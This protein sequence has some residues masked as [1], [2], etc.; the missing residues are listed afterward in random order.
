MPGDASGGLKHCTTVS[1]PIIL[2]LWFC[3]YYYTWRYSYVLLGW[4]IY[5]ISDTGLNIWHCVLKGSC[6]AKCGPITC[7]PPVPAYCV[8]C[9]SQHMSHLSLF[10]ICFTFQVWA[11]T[12]FCLKDPLL[13]VPFTK[14][15]TVTHFPNP[16][17][18]PSLCRACSALVPAER[19]SHAWGCSQGQY[20]SQPWVETYINACGP[21][22]MPKSPFMSL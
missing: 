21:T 20:L 4:R 15:K 8:F 13:P 9:I 11:L 6:W 19:A 3:P 16:V 14:Q 5:L 12:M 18:D 17:S 10:L 22:S 2:P 1:A 7:C